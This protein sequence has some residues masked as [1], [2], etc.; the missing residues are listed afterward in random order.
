LSFSLEASSVN[1]R[2]GY[3]AALRW[4]RTD[5]ASFGGVANECGNSCDTNCLYLEPEVRQGSMRN[6][7]SSGRRTRA[8][9]GSI[10]A[11]LRARTAAKW[12]SCFGA[13]KRLESLLTLRQ[14]AGPNSLAAERTNP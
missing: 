11:R 8:L 10:D 5:T 14:T 1:G 6:Q 13:N 4:Y 7:S 9:C 3:V 12:A 2:R